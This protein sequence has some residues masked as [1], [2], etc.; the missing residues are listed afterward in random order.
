MTGTEYGLI[1]DVEV[2]FGNQSFILLADT[3]SSDTWV[4]RAG[5]RCID[6]AD[7]SELKPEDCQYGTTYDPPDNLAPVD[8]QTF[9][10]Q[11]GTGI[12]MGVVGF[13]D[14]TLASITVHNQ[15]VG[16]VD[17]TTD[18]GDGLISG[19]PGLG[20]PP[21]TSAHPGTNYPNDS[22]LLDRARYDLLVTT[23]LKRGLVEP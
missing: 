11:Y 17:S 6:K 10:L 19:I 3:G 13:K 15:T 18:V 1:Y 23:M 20:Y 9:S 7:S 16:V 12:A 2:Q 8:N 4:V 22:L 14:V 5:F 21:L